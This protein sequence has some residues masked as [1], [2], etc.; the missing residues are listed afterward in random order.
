MRRLL[1]VA[2]G[3]A[4]L[5]GFGVLVT[6]SLSSWIAQH[7]VH[8]D[9]DMNTIGKT[10]FLGVYP[11]LLVIGGWLGNQWHRRRSGKR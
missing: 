10:L 11:G 6:A 8:S 7:L 9:D 3:A 5:L 1:S 2:I 4:L